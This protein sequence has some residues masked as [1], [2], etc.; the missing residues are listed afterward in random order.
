ML[1]V[2]LVIPMEL[3]RTNSDS[4]SA[5]TPNLG[6]CWYLEHPVLERLNV[7]I[8]FILRV[9]ASK[10]MKRFIIVFQFVTQE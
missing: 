7:Q 3:P 5:F 6:E 4:F 2:T 10:Q 9:N 1:K 8:S